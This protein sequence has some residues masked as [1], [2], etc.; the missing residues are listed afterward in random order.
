VFLSAKSGELC[1]AAAGL[2]AGFVFLE[3][4]VRLSGT[5][6][7]HPSGYPRV[8]TD[9]NRRARGP[10]NA[11]GYRDLEHAL[12]K[13][14]GTTRIVVLG[15][16]FTWGAGVEWD[17]TWSEHLERALRREDGG[18]FEVVNLSQPGFGTR[19]EQNALLTE[20]FRYQPDVVVLAYVLN[21]SE[22]GRDAESRRA[23][24]WLAEQRAAAPP[25]F[26]ERSALVSLVLQR[27]R[28]TRESRQRVANY[29]SLYRDDAPGW[30]G[31]QKALREIGGECR[32]RGVP[33]VVAIFPLFGGPLDEHYPFAALHAKV[34]ASAAAAG[35]SVLDLLPSY[36]G[37]RWD[38][39][40]VDGVD[41]EHPNEVAHRIAARAIL[42]AVEDVLSKARTSLP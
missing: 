6:A 12:A 17:D 7:R 37:L 14:A 10:S 19:D 21:D 32:R 11:G 42:K 22:D 35:A 27:L 15:D 36:R 20:G 33:F 38:L 8:N 30:R 5:A 2:L 4:G 29:L 34:A 28:A 41:D 39:L 25:G 3:S 24:R 23:Q 18:A 40:V 26:L 1:L 16:S 9:T 31:A 13:P